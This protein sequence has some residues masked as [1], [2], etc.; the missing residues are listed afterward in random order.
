MTFIPEHNA[1]WIYTN[2]HPVW[3][4]QEIEFDL[5]SMK[6]IFIDEWVNPFRTLSH[7]FFDDEPYVYNLGDSFISFLDLNFDLYNTLL[8]ECL[9]DHANYGD[10]GHYLLN[11]FCKR[12][13]QNNIEHLYIDSLD[14]DKFFN[15]SSSEFKALLHVDTNIITSIRRFV[16]GLSGMPYQ[17]EDNGESV[18]SS[19]DDDLYIIFSHIPFMKEK[20]YC[21]VHVDSP[22]RIIKKCNFGKRYINISPLSFCVTELSKMIEANIK[23][24]RCKNCKKYF[25]QKNNYNTDYCERIYN[26]KGQTCKDIGASLKYKSKM[27]NNP[28]LKEYERAYKRMYARVSKHKMTSDDFRLWTEAAIKKRDLL[29]KKYE[30]TPSEQLV[31]EFK[32]YLGNK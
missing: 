19:L 2:S 24:K 6:T 15:I 17:T 22:T 9:A 30:N 28:I 16:D 13:G 29:S 23:I 20:V 11:D 4:E 18:I 8:N 10:L 7:D 5:I 32:K 26:S 27:N 3:S 14:L 25:I 21:E 12:L 1:E 31:T